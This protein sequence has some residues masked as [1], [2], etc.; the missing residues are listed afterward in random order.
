MQIGWKLRLG[1]ICWD[2]TANNWERWGFNLGVSDAKA[3]F[4]R[5]CGPSFVISTFDVNLH[6]EQHTH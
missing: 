3:Y 4:L 6:P 1:L 2:H 5:H